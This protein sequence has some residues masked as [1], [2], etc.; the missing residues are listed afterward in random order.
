[1]NSGDAAGMKSPLE[2]PLA[3]LTEEDI[4]Q[5]TREDCRRFLKD[6]GMR[7]PSWNKSQ[8][9]Q[10]VIS[11]KAILEG[12]QEEGDPPAA[13]AAVRRKGHPS[14]APQHIA[15]SSPR[16]EAAGDSP[17]PANDPS[18][19]RRRDPIPPVF[20]AVDPSCRIPPENR[21]VSP[22]TAAELPFGQM[23]I[24]YDGKVNVFDG[25][26]PD[27]A[28]A[29]M[30]LAAS[31]V[32]YDCRPVPP[33]L[34]RQPPPRFPPT[35]LAPRPV[36]PASPV[37]GI[38][39]TSPAGLGKSPRSLQVQESVEWRS[40]RETEPECPTSRKAS[41]QRY[42]EKRKDRFKGKRVHGGSSSSRTEMMY[43][44]QKIQGQTS[45]EQLNR[46]NISSLAPPRPPGTPTRCSSVENQAEKICFS[47]D[48][49]DECG[50]N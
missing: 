47:I 2:K 10:Q 35:F 16:K 22:R 11:L 46:T 49:N 4:A 18:P 21:C 25:V 33:P 3:K 20:S 14:P 42:I 37:A 6:K 34:S 48:L 45:N 12:R 9:I 28:R 41:L 19:Y 8:A 50:D 23:T 17:A 32:R 40:L 44:S 31:P 43:F 7:R 5:L 26:T 38:F 27:K 36:H 24:F 29:I 15:P 13:G 39:P 30:H 1:M